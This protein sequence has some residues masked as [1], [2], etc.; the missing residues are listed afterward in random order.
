MRDSGNNQSSKVFEDCFDGLSLF[1]PGVG[2]TIDER[3]GLDAREHGIVAHITQIVGDP[4][5][6]LVRGG[7]E[8]FGGHGHHATFVELAAVGQTP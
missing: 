8:L 2:K 1:G 7:A 5:D 4:I 6:G 3:A